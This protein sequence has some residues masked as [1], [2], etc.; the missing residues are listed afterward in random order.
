MSTAHDLAPLLDMSRLTHVVDIGANP[1]EGA[2]PYRRL[3]DA[4]LCRITGFE[5]QASALAEL[6]RKK[7][8]NETY[9]SYALGDGEER[10]LN[11]CAYSGWTSIFVPSAAALDVF[12]L[13]KNNARILSRARMETRRL[14]DLTEVEDIDF[15]KIDIQG[16]EL[17]VFMHGRNKLRNAVVIQT[18]LQFV[19]LYEGQPS[20]GQVDQELRAQGFIPHAFA[21]L[22][23]W[24][25][26]PLQFGGNPTQ[27]LNQLLE[28]DVVYVRDFVHP[29]D[30]SSDQ[31][32]Q[33]CLIVH[34]CYDSFDLAGRCV[35]L[36][37]QRQVLPPGAL[38]QYIEIINRNQ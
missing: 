5:P 35:A 24:P 30:M 8:A 36:L 22:K 14:D 19:N 27:A 33:L 2:A 25:I 21:A 31:L 34:A 6:N 7:G 9:L 3:L 16:G 11:V 17:A 38:Q 29:E 20:F 23:K 28:A 18:E 15:L 12:S 37:E 1:I 4:R 13:F 10:T 26:S 32:K